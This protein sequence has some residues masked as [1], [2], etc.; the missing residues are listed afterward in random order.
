MLVEEEIKYF[1]TSVQTLTVFP[2]SLLGA[3]FSGKHSVKKDAQ[4]RIFIDRNGKLFEYVLDFLRDGE[5]AI[6]KKDE[7][8]KAKFIKAKYFILDEMVAFLEG[9]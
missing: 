7:H 6:D 3:M 9:K 1:T 2:H 5:I 8:L 4:G